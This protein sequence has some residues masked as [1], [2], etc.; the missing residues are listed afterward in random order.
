MV[1]ADPK[2]AW[3]KEAE[4]RGDV[5]W[6]RV[7]EI[8]DSYSYSQSGM[9]PATQLAV[10][11]VVTYLT[12]GA[13]SS[14]VGVAANSVPG[15]VANSVAAAVSSNA[16]I[17]TV[18]N[19]G[20]L[21][22]V[23]KDVT[24]SDSLKSYVAAGVSGGIGNANLG[25]QLAVNSAMKT[26][27]QGGKFKDN[28]AQAAVSM[29]AD[30][31]SGALYEKVGDGLAGAGLPT[32]VAVH[33]IVGGLIGEAAG[34]DFRTAAL[35][36]GANEA[37]VNLVGEKLFPGEAHERVLAMTSQ[38][39]GMTVA[40]A[41]GG[42]DKD[43][44]KAGW[45]AQQATVNNYLDHRDVDELAKELVG[46]R[47]NPDPVACR[48]QVQGKYQAIND[49]KAGASLYGC[50]GEGETACNAQRN[51]VEAGSAKLDWLFGLGTL[52]ADEQD[53]IGHFQD[54]NHNEERV[55]QHAWLESFLQGS[56]VIGGALLGGA[57]GLAAAQRGG[58]GR[59]W[60]EGGC[61]C[62]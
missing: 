22:A 28:L 62:C 61:G 18:N 8:H 51:A 52:N 49:R 21:G 31:L 60:G 26:V 46:C 16:A 2:L 12:W 15:V 34:G 41:A 11:I 33:A 5:D 53:V 42:S 36:A 4:Q 6:R 32:K 25:L 1:Q 10:A 59:G 45:V 23:T 47:S 14:L 9:G 54:I 30:L 20:D 19:R 43:Q 56:G 7:K 58:C 40:A 50:K 55:A 39:L 57:A 38:L 44:E 48:G 13:G 3:L 27:L 17:S 24:S 37:L 35:A 29:A